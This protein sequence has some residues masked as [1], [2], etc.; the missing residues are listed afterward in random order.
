MNDISLLGTLDQNFNQ[1]WNL[2]DSN[3]NSPTLHAGMGGGGGQVP[4]IL[5]INDDIS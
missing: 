2:Y 1:H 3:Y 5:V 4:M